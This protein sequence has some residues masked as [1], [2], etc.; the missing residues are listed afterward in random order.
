MSAPDHWH[1]LATV[2]AAE[3]GKHVY[4]EKPVSHNLI[5]GRR[6]VEAAR[7]YKV[8]VQAGTQR[9]S[10]PSVIAA[11]EYV[12]AGKL[13]K[14]AFARAWIAGN[15]PNIGYAKPEAAAEGRRLRP[16]ARAGVRRVHQEPLPLQLALVLGSRHRRTRQQ[17][18]PR[19][20]PRPQRAR[21]STPRRR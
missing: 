20:R 6:M 10:Q 14:V 3:R 19:A 9:R 8:V 12:Q 4:V 15:R 11:R 16:V 18:H 21:R 17:R 2:W 13:G 5:E 1:A 7:K